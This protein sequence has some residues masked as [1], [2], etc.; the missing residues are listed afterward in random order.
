MKN[1]DAIVKEYETRAKNT[2]KA[3]LKRRGLTYSQLA[4]R[5]K[6]HGIDENERN[7]GNKISRG[8]FTTA[9]FLMCMDVIGASTLQLDT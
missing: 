9:F 7:L 8:S 4:E 3:E 2:L 5:L 6:E 1:K